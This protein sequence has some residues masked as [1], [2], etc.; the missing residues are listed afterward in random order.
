[1]N[2]FH[3]AARSLFLMATALIMM[4]PLVIPV[5]NSLMSEKEIASNYGFI[6]KM[7]DAGAG[8]KDLF[9]NLK[10]IPDWVSFEQYGK[11]L[12]ETPIFL[13]MFWNSVL[14]VVPSCYCG[15]FKRRVF[16]NRNHMPCKEERG[17]A[18]RCKRYRE[19]GQNEVAVASPATFAESGFVLS[20]DGVKVMGGR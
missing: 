11:I 10:L 4:L 2:V 17:V 1:M 3:K 18:S 20:E 5:T 8:A 13:N 12:L 9:V 7:V 15:S 19:F 6:G 16:R 14:L